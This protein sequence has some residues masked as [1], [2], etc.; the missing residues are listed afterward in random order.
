MNNKISQ[1]NNA[2]W[3]KVSQLAVGMEIAVPKEDAMRRQ[4]DRTVKTD[5]GDDILWDEIISIEHIGREQ[6]WDIEVE[7]T[8]NFVGNGIFAHNTYL[9][10]PTVSGS[11]TV[12]SSG[13]GIIDTMGAI[14]N[15]VLTKVQ[16]LWASGDII[17]EGIKK[18]YFALSEVFQGLNVSELIANW[19]FTESRFGDTVAVQRVG[20]PS[21]RT[22]KDRP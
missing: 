21:R 12:T 11:V 3:K 9:G 8:R 2:E 4:E 14:A 10:S 6:V 13:T 20:R 19:N 16:S 15:A 5:G 1:L 7:G 18:T 22:I 17:T